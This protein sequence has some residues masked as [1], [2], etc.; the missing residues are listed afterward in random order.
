ML[1]KVLK[2]LFVALIV[3]CFIGIISVLFEKC[4]RSNKALHSRIDSLNK[5]NDSLSN[6]IRINN[7]QISLLFEKD[8]FLTTQLIS[9]KGKVT[10]VNRYIDSSKHKIDSLKDPQLI[11]TFNERYPADTITNKLFL[12]RPVLISI[13]KDLV[14]LDGAR[15]IIPLQD[16]MIMLGSSKMSIK[17]SIITKYKINEELFNKQLLNKNIEI[18]DLYT[19]YNN[20]YRENKKLNTKNKFQ[21]ILTYIIIGGATYALMHK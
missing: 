18:N 21:K 7:I 20:L 4:S 16:S 13:A 15:K 2:G 6:V 9:A 1:Q 17:D 12:A 8:S 14:E 10:I 5:I 3:M 19:Q 11:R